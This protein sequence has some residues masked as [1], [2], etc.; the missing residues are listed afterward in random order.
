M[1]RKAIQDKKFK[2][3]KAEEKKEK[4][5]HV[6]QFDIL[7]YARK[8][9]AKENYK[10]DTSNLEAF[11]ELDLGRLRLL[12]ILIPLTEKRQIEKFI[13]YFL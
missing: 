2:K 5:V 11:N 1:R 10:M 3:I 8:Q 13:N 7:G 6:P 12:R 9:K 4:A